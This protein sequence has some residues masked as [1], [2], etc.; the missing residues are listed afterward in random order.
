MVKSRRSCLEIRQKD[1]ERALNVVVESETRI[2]EDTDDIYFDYRV[3]IF[4]KETSFM[5]PGLC[6]GAGL[7]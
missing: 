5:G 7:C 4:T 3:V 6:Y 2:I 1:I